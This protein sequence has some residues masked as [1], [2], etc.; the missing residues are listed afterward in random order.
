MNEEI[1]AL[2]GTVE[3]GALRHAALPAFATV[4]LLTG[5]RVQVAGWRTRI[6]CERLLPVPGEQPYRGQR[7]ISL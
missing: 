1:G 3:Y 6:P 5:W 2:I 4:R 7:L